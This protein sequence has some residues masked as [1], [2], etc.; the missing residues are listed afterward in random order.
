MTCQV[1]KRYTDLAILEEDIWRQRA[2]LRWE[3]QGDKNT[4]YFHA[5]A[6][7][8]KRNNTVMQ[9][10][11]NGQQYS[12][13]RAKA[14]AFFQFYKELMGKPSQPTPPICWEILYGQDQ[15]DLQS[16]QDPITVQ[17]VQ[18]VIQT[19]PRN[20]SPGPDGFTG[21][22]YIK[23]QHILIRDIHAVLSNITAEG[24]SLHPLNTSY[25]IL[26]PKKANSLHPQDY[27]PISLVHGMQRIFSKILANRVQQHIPRLVSEEQT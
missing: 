17:E 23:Y 7:S 10:E 21:E 6:S 2:K 14:E 13:Q 22:F 20:K 3:L 11:W 24:G 12:D 9:I 5:L 4:R 16:L 18:Q 25:I 19:W 26:I 15:H 27:R 8:S 1:K